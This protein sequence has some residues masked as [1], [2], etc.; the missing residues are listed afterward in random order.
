[1]RPF[2]M[3]HK[4]RAALYR[5]HEIILFEVKHSAWADTT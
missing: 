2:A 4:Y 5:K 1:M 3:D